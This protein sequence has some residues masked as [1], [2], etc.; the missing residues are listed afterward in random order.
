MHHTELLGEKS[1]TD[2][3]LASHSAILSDANKI[4]RADNGQTASLEQRSGEAVFGKELYLEMLGRFSLL[5][6]LIT[7][8]AA[9]TCRVRKVCTEDA[10]IWNRGK[11]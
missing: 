3:T 9:I 4:L 11:R 1:E 2:G 6:H 7:G 5:D 10:A 8:L